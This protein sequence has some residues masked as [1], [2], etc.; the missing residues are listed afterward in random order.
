MQQKIVFYSNQMA[1]FNTRE[2]IS[3]N[4]CCVHK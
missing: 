2:N 3:I 1:I 4:M